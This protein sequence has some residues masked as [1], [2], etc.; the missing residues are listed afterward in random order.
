MSASCILP[1]SSITGRHPYLIISSIIFFILCSFS[2]REQAFCCA[3]L[4]VQYFFKIFKAPFWNK[5]Q[6]LCSYCVFVFFF[7]LPCSFFSSGMLSLLSMISLAIVWLNTREVTWNSTDL[8]LFIHLAQYDHFPSAIDTEKVVAFL[9]HTNFY[10]VVIT[11]PPFFFF[12]HI[13][14]QPNNKILCR[15]SM[16][17][18]LVRWVFHFC[19]C[20]NYWVFIV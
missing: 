11:W 10:V 7:Y 14:S 13:C 1:H 19:P 3:F 12:P 9:G 16:L 8:L 20:C 4:L 5:L 15:I 2:F 17:R 6:L 18:A